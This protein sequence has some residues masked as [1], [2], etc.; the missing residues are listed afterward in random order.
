LNDSLLW[1]RACWVQIACSVESGRF[2]A[3]L[4]EAGFQPGDFPEPA[5]EL[6]L[7]DTVAR[8][9]DDLNQATALAKFELAPLETSLPSKP[10]RRWR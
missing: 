3:G 7:A 8:V 2:P 5:V 9:G 1:I 10:T 4:D 6:G